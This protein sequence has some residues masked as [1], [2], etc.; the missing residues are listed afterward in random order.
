M[1]TFKY[2]YT[3]ISSSDGQIQIAIWAILAIWFEIF[4]I[5]FEKKLNHGKS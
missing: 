3:D 1:L 4:A 2:I 5:W